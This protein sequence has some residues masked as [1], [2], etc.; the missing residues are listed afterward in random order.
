MEKGD[1][2][3]TMI[4]MGVSGWMFL[5]VP[6]Y[7][8]CPGSKAVKQSLLLLLLLLMTSV[9]WHCWLGVKKS[10]R[11]VK[12]IWVMRCSCGYLSGVMC[13]LYPYGPADA[14]LSQNPIIFSSF[15]SRLVFPF[16]YRLTQVVLEK[17]LLKRWNSSSYYIFISVDS[18]LL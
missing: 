18:R 11:S 3:S 4:R 15:K 13:R 10:I 16:W 2:G 14:T 17:R 7:P 1:K 12:K 5:L 8:G 6:A 9:L